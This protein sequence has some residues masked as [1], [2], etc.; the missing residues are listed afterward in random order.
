MAFSKNGLIILE[1]KKTTCAAHYVC[2]AIMDAVCVILHSVF[3]SNVI[4]DISPTLPAKAADNFSIFVNKKRENF[5]NSIVI[6]D[7]KHFIQS[8]GYRTIIIQ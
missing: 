2:A 8:R 6:D 3:S 4:V 1:Q 5:R 7:P